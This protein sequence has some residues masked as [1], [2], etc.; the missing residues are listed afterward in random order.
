MQRTA[1]LLT[2]FALMLVAFAAVS[3]GCSCTFSGYSY[4]NKAC[5]GAPHSCSDHTVSGGECVEVNGA[6]AYVNCLSGVFHLYNTTDCS[7]PVVF[8]GV[9]DQCYLNGDS[10]TLVRWNE[11]CDGNPQPVENSEECEPVPEPQEVCFMSLRATSSCK[12]ASESVCIGEWWFNHNQCANI[13]FGAE[14]GILVD[15]TKRI[16]QV[17]ADTTNCTGVAFAVVDDACSL[18][19]GPAMLAKWGE[20]CDGEP[21]E[22][23]DE[24]E[25]GSQSQD[26]GSESEGDGSSA[27]TLRL[28][29]LL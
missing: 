20:T 2:Q 5:H 25:D 26:G 15:C 22:A 6:S 11:D 1:L 10:S 24:E 9:P 27:P 28:Q 14:A 4:D 3:K 16:A 23:S 7:G 12:E 18:T 19:Y 21:R 29:I 13:T 8:G 17:F